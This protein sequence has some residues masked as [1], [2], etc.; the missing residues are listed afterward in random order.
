LHDI[1]KINIREVTLTRSDPLSAEEWADIRRHSVLGSEMVKDISYLRPAYEVIRHH[2]ER[3]DGK[4][5]PDGLAGEAIPFGARLV[6][7]ADCFDAMTTDR[8]YSRAR[9]LEIACQEIIRC[10]G[11]HFDPAVVRAFLSAW[12][13]GKIQTIFSSGWSINLPLER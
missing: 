10:S 8:P 12:Q 9:S 11:S 7:V 13:A 5:Y 3:W 2:H 6:C 1:G 4:G